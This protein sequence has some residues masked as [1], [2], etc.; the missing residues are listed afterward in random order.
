VRVRLV[1]RVPGS[2]RRCAVV[3]VY[4]EYMEGASGVYGRCMGLVMPVVCLGVPSAR[5]DLTRRSPRRR[6]RYR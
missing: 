4:E 1:E 5:E 6:S 3:R 2:S